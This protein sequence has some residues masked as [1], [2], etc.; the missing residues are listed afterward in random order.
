MNTLPLGQRLPILLL[1]AAFLF[2][3]CSKEAATVTSTAPAPGTADNVA[4][5]LCDALK[6]I[7]PPLSK[8][9]PPMAK[10]QFAGNLYGAF[11]NAPTVIPELLARSDEIASR[12]CPAERTLILRATDSPSLRDALQ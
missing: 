7:A 8:S 5:Q 1:A 3:G 4:K 11:D 12:D 10:A 2:A 6:Q 9:P